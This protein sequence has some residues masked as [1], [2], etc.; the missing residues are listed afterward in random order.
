M[1]A[2][3]A[4]SSGLVS[5]AGPLWGPLW[6]LPSGVAGKFPERWVKD[7]GRLVQAVD[8]TRCVFA[9]PMTERDLGVARLPAVDPFRIT[10]DTRFRD[11]ISPDNFP[12]LR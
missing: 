2:A 5:G 12:P 10:R 1:D 11:G 7:F 8:S 6:A 4:V 3:A 9:V